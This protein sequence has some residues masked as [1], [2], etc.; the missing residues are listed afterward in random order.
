[1]CLF[2]FLRYTIHTHSCM[3]SYMLCYFS[4][5]IMLEYMI[6]RLSSKESEIVHLCLKWKFNFCNGQTGLCSYGYSLYS[7]LILIV[8][9]I[10]ISRRRFLLFSFLGELPNH[11]YHRVSNIKDEP[12]I[13]SIILS[14]LWA[15]ACAT[16]LCINFWKFKRSKTKKQ[17][18]KKSEEQRPNIQRDKNKKQL[19][20]FDVATRPTGFKIN[21]KQ[22]KNWEA[23]LQR[24]A[25]FT[26]WVLII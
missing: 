4:L 14:S 22:I 16:C 2:L 6:L 7:I 13:Y 12:G 8:I 9:L 11:W 20:I 17:K 21:N 19:Y 25:Y 3:D 24:N 26:S 1:M 18:N 23:P 15:Y 5:F 10:W